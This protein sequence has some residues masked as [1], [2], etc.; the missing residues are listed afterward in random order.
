MVCVGSVWLS[1]KF[2]KE[3]FIKTLR[4]VEKGERCVGKLSLLKLSTS[5]AVGATY[6]AA[7]AIQC[8]MPRDYQKNYSV[9]FNY[10]PVCKFP[11]TS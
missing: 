10:E 1:W 7:D 6:L 2:L 4:T 5:M 3:G 9:F 11:K 8:D